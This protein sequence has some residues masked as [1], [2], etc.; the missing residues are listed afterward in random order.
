MTTN[1]ELESL[2]KKL[3]IRYFNGCIMMD[4][5]PSKRIKENKFI[6]GIV[7]FDKTSGPGTHWVAYAHTD[8]DV[9]YYFDSYGTEAPIK[10]RE[11]LGPTLI[12]T[13]DIQKMGTNICGELCLLFLLCFWKYGFVPTV[14][15]MNMI[16]EELKYIKPTVESI[17]HFY[18][19][20]S[21]LFNNTITS[22]YDETSDSIVRDMINLSGDGIDLHGIGQKIGLKP[23]FGDKGLTLPGYNYFGPYN[24]I[25]DDIKPTNVVDEIAREHDINYR[26]GMDKTEA[27][28]I[29]L[30]RLDAVTPKNTTEAIGKFI[31][32]KVIGLKHFLK[33]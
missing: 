10:I 2:A 29:M 20:I 32:K 7:N 8:E 30:E 17:F 4:E 15:A 13:Y 3:R 18:K 19:E 12:S 22:R 31:G 23:I 28:R 9:G 16:R 33:V 25:S 26:D 11:Y 5:V 27:D 1:I 6:C 21:K 14:F 24:K